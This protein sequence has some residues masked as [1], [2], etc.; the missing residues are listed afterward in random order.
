MGKHAPRNCPHYC[1]RGHERGEMK[2]NL[3]WASSS[4]SD[5]SKNG[6]LV[7]QNIAFYCERG[8]TIQ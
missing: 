4:G 7:G 3:K 8:K 1:F 2:V 5:K 6:T